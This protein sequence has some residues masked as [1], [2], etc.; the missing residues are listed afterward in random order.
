MTKTDVPQRNVHPS[1]S[2]RRRWLIGSAL[3]CA[4][5]TSLAGNGSAQPPRRSAE[6]PRRA[7][8]RGEQRS[9]TPHPLQQVMEFAAEGREALKEVK[10]Y[11]AIFT[12]TEL[13][14][15]KMVKHQMEMKFREKP[16]SVY[17]RFRSGN[18]AGREVIYVAGANRGNLLVHETG[19][20][21]VAGT[22]SVK[23]NGHEVMEE[24]RYP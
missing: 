19:I 22:V 24:N 16:F 14:D 2:R 20:K 9:T 17:F 5:M 10:D 13:V 15:R 1:V 21:A 3:A 4:A 6:P 7:P 8:E 18:E 12:K 11:T 23:P